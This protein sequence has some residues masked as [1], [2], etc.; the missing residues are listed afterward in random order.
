MDKLSGMSCKWILSLFDVN[1][2]VEYKIFHGFKKGNESRTGLVILLID[3][4]KCL[5]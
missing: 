1:V 5:L 2:F 4:K 3:Q